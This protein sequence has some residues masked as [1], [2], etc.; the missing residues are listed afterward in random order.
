[1]K[2]VA[3]GPER[4]SRVCLKYNFGFSQSFAIK[5]IDRDLKLIHILFFL[6][7]LYEVEVKQTGDKFFFASIQ[8][9]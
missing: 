9:V 4:F 5:D 7:D 6:E 2:A 1:M 8:S 3:E